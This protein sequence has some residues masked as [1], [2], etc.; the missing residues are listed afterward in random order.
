MSVYRMREASG[1][2]TTH[3]KNHTLTDERRAER[4]DLFKYQFSFTADEISANPHLETFGKATECQHTFDRNC[5][6]PMKVF[7]RTWPGRAKQRDAFIAQFKP[8]A[9]RKLLR[10]HHTT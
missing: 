6:N 9:W 5:S 7:S 10:L 4:L 8:E 1:N 3:R 2:L